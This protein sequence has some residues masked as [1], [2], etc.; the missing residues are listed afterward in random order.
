MAEIGRDID[1]AAVLLA[2]G[3]LVAIPTETVYGLSGNAFNVNAISKIFEVKDRPSFNPLIVHTNRLEK[4]QS[5]VKEIPPLAQELVDALWPGPLTLLLPRNEIIP[6]LVTAGSPRVAVRI[7]NHSLSL[8]LLS[9][10]EFPLAAPS[11]NPFGYISPTMASH[12][13][14]QLGSK[15]SYILDG[16]PSAI[17]IESTI[18][19]FDEFGQ[20]EVYRFGGTPIEAIENICGPLHMNILAKKGPKAPGMLK[21]H[22][23]PNTQ[24]IVCDIAATIP[25]LN[26]AKTGVLSFNKMYEGIPAQNQR[27]LS[28]T[29]DL[30]EAAHELF[31][32]MRD[33]DSMGLEIILA[34]EV[35]DIGLGKAIN[36]RLKRAAEER[37]F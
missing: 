14:E 31:A 29:S 20:V 33:L 25:R 23:A 7:P 3:E 4:I 21:S 19:G 15:I 18:V 9:A 12:V 6:D 11:A 10:I 35:P 30:H 26:P 32:T 37:D 34:E 27:T 28:I 36:D 24:L 22:Y 16:G 5:F 2:S 8:E 13:Q 1:K 17:G